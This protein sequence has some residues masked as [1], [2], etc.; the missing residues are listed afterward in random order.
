[1][2]TRRCGWSDRFSKVFRRWLCRSPT[3]R[4]VL[5]YRRGQKFD[6]PIERAIHQAQSGLDI[7]RTRRSRNAPSGP[8]HLD[9]GQSSCHSRRRHTR[10][11]R[12]PQVSAPLDLCKRH[13]SPAGCFCSDVPIAACHWLSQTPA[14]DWF[15]F[16][17]HRWPS[18]RQRR[19]L[20]PDWIVRDRVT[21]QSTRCPT[22][23][24]T[25]RGS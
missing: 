16:A 24:T 6:P 8:L 21:W 15:P 13:F 14:P 18:H 20:V 19:Q 12:R 2:T 23:E 9:S 5:R 10:L 4:R 22:A 11:A 7:F 3:D 25:P 17:V 1:M